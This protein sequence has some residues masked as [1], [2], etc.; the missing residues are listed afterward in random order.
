MTHPTDR[1]IDILEQFAPA[2]PLPPLNV[3]VQSSLTPQ[4]YDI[5][6]TSPHN[7]SS[8]SAFKL[9]GVNIYRSFDSEFGP[10][11][12]INSLPI[13]AEFY[14]DKTQVQLAVEENVS[15]RFYSRGDTD[16]STRWIFKTLKKPIHIDSNTSHPNRTNLNVFV[17][18]NGV[19]AF[20]ENVN[21]TEGEVELR[22]IPSFDPVSQ[23]QV[24]AV[25][26]YS[27]DDEVLVSYRYISSFVKSNMATRV[28]Y[29]VTTVAVDPQSGEEIETPL[30]RASRSSNFAIESLDYIWREGV[31]RNKFLLVQGGERVKLFIRK[32]V[33]YGCG[34]Y[35]E[36]RGQ[37][38]SSCLSCFGTGFM[39]GYEGPFDILIAP[40]DAKKS[41]LQ[42]NR[43]QSLDHTY[44]TWTGPAPLISQRD[45][46][47]KLNGDRYV[48]GPVS[49]PTN[50]GNVLQQMFSISHLDETDIRY[51]VP[52][53]DPSS[54]IAPQTRYVGTNTYPIV[55]ERENLDDSRELRG[56]SVAYSNINRR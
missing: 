1:G 31:R 49:M 3:F 36:T 35:S 6:W 29:S 23:T 30:D 45:F 4:S 26:P 41:K 11:E 24:P 43:G 33:G 46:L 34:C 12:K 54:L 50:R 48:I 47:V 13:G 16:P 7:L 18:V 37:P 51:R 40:D 15:E 14:R 5:R 20:V 28:F 27:F 44:D 32:S 10:Y 22:K 55:T 53:P 42:S 17:T 19:P 21:A 52:L 25:L 8:N 56:N 9:I 2:H 39:G 38:N